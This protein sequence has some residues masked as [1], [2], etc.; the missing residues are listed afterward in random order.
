M[1]Y[2]VLLVYLAVALLL[3]F[4]VGDFPVTFMAFPLNLIVFCLWLGVMVWIWTTMRKS[5]F[6]RFML[7]PGAT[8]WS[9]FLFVDACVVIGLTGDRT[10]AVSWPFVAILLFLQTVLLF[11]I[12]RG[13]REATPT[14][15][16]LGAVR[17]RFLLN[18]VG[19]LLA[20]GAAFWGAPDSE[21]I[22]F[23]A[24]IG[25]KV[26]YGYYSNGMRTGLNHDVILQ[27]FRLERYEN[28]TPSLYEASVLVDGESVSLRVNHPHSIG[29]GKDLYL[30]SYDAAAGNESEYCIMQIVSEPWRY[31]ALTGVLMM[32]AGAFLL[33]IRGPKS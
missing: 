20:I 28:G 30:V 2:I 10:M 15:A 24:F 17:W 12:F 19:L 21:E 4:F 18:H 31:G 22:R 11:V 27:D 8:F 5:M 13:W 1:P 6:V 9:I 25:Q 33:F 26:E 3:Q 16:R 29:F 14:G 32:L 23:Q 7:S